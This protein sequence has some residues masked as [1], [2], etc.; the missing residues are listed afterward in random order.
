[1]KDSMNG[2]GNGMGNGKMSMGRQIPG[3]MKHAVMLI[4]SGK[5]EGDNCPAA[6]QDIK[7]NLKNRAKAITTA[8]YGPMNPAEKNQDFWRKKAEAWGSASIKDAKSS[9]CGNCSAFNV[10]SEMEDCIANGIGSEGDPWGMIEAGDMGYCEIFDFKCAGSRTCD[11][12]V[13][14]GPNEGDGQE[15]DTELDMPQDK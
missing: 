15:M 12:W 11:A 5:P 7:V 8:A 10:S 4:M 3:A 1:M 2:M 13:A 6:T 14:G 9:R